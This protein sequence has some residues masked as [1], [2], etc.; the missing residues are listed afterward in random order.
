MGKKRE[1]NTK[2]N[3]EC[4]LEHIP[5]IKMHCIVGKSPIEGTMAI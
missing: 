5:I 2:K 4:G 3:E 1:K